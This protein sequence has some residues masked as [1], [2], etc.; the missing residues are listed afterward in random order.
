MLV[1]KKKATI[2]H[3]TDVFLMRDPESEIE[4]SL[5]S[6]DYFRAATYLSAVLEYYGRLAIEEKLKKG[7]RPV[8]EDR[9]DNLG[10]EE[11]VIMLFGL[12]ILEQP[13]YSALIG[14]N[15]TRNKLL[16]IRDFGNFRA[17]QGKE[18]ETVI[19]NAM[20]CLGKLRSLSP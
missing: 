8:D 19:R 6:G 4:Q 3:S 13:C 14:L 1:P 10:A 5:K 17:I 11:V 18:T 2:S 7:E 20:D 9:L 12:R 16:H 15:K